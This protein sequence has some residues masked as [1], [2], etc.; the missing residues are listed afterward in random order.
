MKHLCFKLMVFIIFVTLAFSGTAQNWRL[1]GNPGPPLNSSN[2]ILGTNSNLSIRF[3]TNNTERMR[4]TANGL[5]GIGTTAPSS[6][7]EVNAAPLGTGEVFR[8]NAPAA[9]NTFW[10]MFRGGQQIGGLFNRA[11]DFNLRIGSFQFGA[12]IVFHSRFNN[13]GPFSGTERMRISHGAIPASAPQIVPDLPN[14]LKEVTRVTISEDPSN[15]IRNPLSLLHLGFSAPGPASNQ[16]GYRTWM[17]VG[18]FTSVGSDNM[19]V[20]MRS[21]TALSWSDDQSAIISWGNNPTGGGSADRMRFVFT[22]QMG[23]TNLLS[24]RQDG[25]EIARMVSNGNVGRMV[26]MRVQT[27]SIR[28][29]YVLMSPLQHSTQQ[30]L[31]VLPVAACDSAT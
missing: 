3:Q 30:R 17:D 15:P 26:L 20:G 27:Q 9:Q 1:G 14:G 10:R 4:L 22:S 16:G 13:V 7:L 12:D 29:R 21:E 5:L 24:G 18:T 28:L 19:Y 6:V 23:T 2:N 31:Q 8:T 11:N 25:L